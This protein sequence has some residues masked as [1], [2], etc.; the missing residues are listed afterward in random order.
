MKKLILLPVLALLPSLTH[1]QN[2]VGKWDF[3]QGN[4]NN[5]VSATLNGILHGG[6]TPVTGKNGNPNTAMRFD[7]SSGYIEIPASPALN[8]TT[9][10]IALSLKF[11]DFYAGPCQVSRL[12]S[13][14]EQFGANF[15]ALEANDNT[16]DNSCSIQ[17][18]SKQ[19][20]CSGPA[21]NTNNTWTYT[22]YIQKDQWYCVVATYAND[23]L[24]MYLD[25]VLQEAR[26]WPNQY[27]SSPATDALLIGR[28]LGANYPYWFNGV[29]DYVALYDGAVDG[30]V[31]TICGNLDDGP[32]GIQ[33]A[34][35][36][37]NISLYPNPASHNLQLTLPASWR[38]ATVRILN[39]TGQLLL[40]RP[41]GTSGDAVDI[42]SL[43]QGVY[44]VEIRHEED[45]I[46]KQLVV[47]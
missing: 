32:T 40:Q 42:S 28:A 46:I 25:G 12:V 47:E 5:S 23:T 31:P 26:Y 38:G 8:L 6:V 16:Y 37:N 22:Q 14:G 7:G 44:Q 17:T 30:T 15:Y 21:G 43:A 45:R 36:A 1:A 19:L 11:N 33:A 13:H 10:S 29:I 9:W 18:P 39:V 35:A 2:L 34:T 27:I 4:A 20:F 41:L 3:N 24:K